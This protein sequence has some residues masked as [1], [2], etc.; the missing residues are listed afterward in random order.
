MAIRHKGLLAWLKTATDEEIQEAG[1]TRDH[2]KLI[3]YGY[4]KAS[5]EVAA[6][7][8]VVT[9]GVVTRKELFPD[10]WER[11]WPELKAA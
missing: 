7:A 5:P 9:K 2:L 6:V 11:I 4:R 3:G 8:E 1:V 10:T